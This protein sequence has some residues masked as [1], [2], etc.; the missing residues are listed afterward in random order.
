MKRYYL[1]NNGIIQ[2]TPECPA[3]GT[4]CKPQPVAV[5]AYEDRE[6]VERLVEELC[7]GQ[8]G[9]RWGDE[10]V[11]KMQAA[12]REFAAPTPRIEEP[13]GLGAVVETVHGELYVRDK[14]TTTVAHWKRA[15]GEERGQRHRW[16]DLSVVRVLSEGVKAG[17]SE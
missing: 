12:L 16:S 4:W 1:H 6:Q 2:D 8:W 5:I 15:R 3:E 14:T 11:D 10:Q 17:E 7:E 13:T 9:H